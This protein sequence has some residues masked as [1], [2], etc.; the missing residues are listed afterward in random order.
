MFGPEYLKKFFEH[1]KFS[2]IVIHKKLRYFYF[3]L[4]NLLTPNKKRH[5]V[6]I[7]NITY[8]DIH[9][10][11]ENR[12]RNSLQVFRRG[13]YDVFKSKKELF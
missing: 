12:P 4:K 1:L 10:N 5:F 2:K 6:T 9:K 7:F 13:I 11:L 8:L 3:T